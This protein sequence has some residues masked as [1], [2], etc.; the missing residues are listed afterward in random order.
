MLIVIHIR[1]YFFDHLILHHGDEEKGMSCSTNQSASSA[2]NSFA[3]N[4]KHCGDA[5]PRS[6]CQFAVAFEGA[7]PGGFGA[8]FGIPSSPSQEDHACLVCSSRL[9]GGHAGFGLLSSLGGSARVA[10]PVHVEQTSALRADECEGGQF[11]A[12][13]SGSA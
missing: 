4:E 7:S 3:Q 1:L 12:V 6:G 11:P 10:G 9:L 2:Q 13:G 5:R 8:R